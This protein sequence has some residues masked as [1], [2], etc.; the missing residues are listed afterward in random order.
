MCRICSCGEKG[1]WVVFLVH[2]WLLESTVYAS[3]YKD[4]SIRRP[5]VASV[6]R[7]VP[8]NFRMTENVIFYVP[9]TTKFDLGQEKVKDIF[10]YSFHF[11]SPLLPLFFVFAYLIT[12]NFFTIFMTVLVSSCCF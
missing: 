11:L 9:L 6:R 12:L 3:L 1:C 2:K 7:S 5:V 8:Y 10:L 4:L